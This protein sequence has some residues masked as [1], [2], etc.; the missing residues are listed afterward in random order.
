MECT[1]PPT[2][3]TAGV[4][5]VHTLQ[6]GS[7]SVQIGYEFAP[8]G[9][10]TGFASVPPDLAN[11]LS[12]YNRTDRAPVQRALAAGATL[13]L[14]LFVDG[15]R[16]ESFYGGAATITTVTGNTVASSSLT[17]SFVNTAGLDCTV[18]S[19]VLQL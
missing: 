13:S 7:Q 16:V 12:N 17:S 1:V 10:T 11:G 6:A 14:N 8:N 3:P 19:W 4:V 5:A 2:P 9:S 15:D 18:Q